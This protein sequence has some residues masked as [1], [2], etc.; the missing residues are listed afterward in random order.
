MT[1]SYTKIN[2][3]PYKTNNFPVQV[4]TPEI[5]T[6]TAVAIFTLTL[7]SDKKTFVSYRCFWISFDTV[8]LA[9][10]SLD[11]FFNSKQL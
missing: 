5:S 4:H 8:S 6:S 10:N 7:L 3:K 9:I 2:E 1:I 11:I